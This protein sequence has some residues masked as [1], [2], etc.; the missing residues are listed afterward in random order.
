MPDRQQYLD[1]IEHAKKSRESKKDEEDE[2]E[3]EDPS[4]D[5]GPNYQGA[6]D[7]DSKSVSIRSD[8]GEGN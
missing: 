3:E 6:S 8:D 1:S 5:R 4:S 7:F 2:V